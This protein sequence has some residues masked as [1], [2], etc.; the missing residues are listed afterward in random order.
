MH[1]PSARDR[2]TG[3]ARAEMSL[4]AEWPEGDHDAWVRTAEEAIARIHARKRYQHGFAHL[5]L[6]MALA[7]V[8]RMRWRGSRRSPIESAQIDAASIR[9]YFGR[10]LV[11]WQAGRLARCEQTA[12]DQPQLAQTN[13][14]PSLPAGRGRQWPTMRGDLQATRHFETVVAGAERLHFICVRD[15]FFAQIL[16]YLAPGDA[17]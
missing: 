6:G 12:A 16:A 5:M 14:C 4:L 2:V 7:T 3:A 17:R 9:G 8:G 13:I 11:L 1:D 10:V 15:A